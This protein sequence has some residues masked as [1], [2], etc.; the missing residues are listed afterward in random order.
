M[1]NHAVNVALIIVL[2]LGVYANTFNNAFVW[3]DE[4]FITENREIK[5][6][7]KWP[8]FFMQGSQN[9]YRPLRTA[10]YAVTWRFGGADPVL[11]HIVGKSLNTMAALVL[12]LLLMLLFASPPAAFWGTLLWALHP[13]HTEKVAFIT[14]TYD[15]LGDLFWLSAFACYVAFRK[16][17]R[18][19]WW[20]ASLALFSAGLFSAETAAVLPLLVV[21][22]DLTF[23]GADKKPLRWSPYFALLAVWLVI[24]TA[25]LGTVA[26]AGEHA[27]NPD[28]WGNLLTMAGVVSGYIKLL[29]FPWPLSVDYDV[30]AWG[31]P[32]LTFY[33]AALLITAALALA[34][35]RAKKEP[36]LAFSVFW[37]FLVL[38]PN[39]NIIPTGTL[40]TERYVYMPSAAIAF[41]AAAYWSRPT[42]SSA[43]FRAASALFI[44]VAIVFFGLTATRNRD[45]R[46]ETALWSATLKTNPHSNVALLNLGVDAFRKKEYPIAERLLLLAAAGRPERMAAPATL[47]DL[48]LEQKR[49]AEAEEWYRRSY[50]AGRREI[51]LLNAAMAAMGKGEFSRV[52]NELREIAERN[53]HS[54][55]ALSALG[56]ALCAEKREGWTPAFVRA[57]RASGEADPVL[58]LAS[59]YRYMGNMEGGRRIAHIGGLLFPGE[60]AF[61]EFF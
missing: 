49:F 5:D 35:R 40:M 47:G 4:L 2:S 28:L 31:P 39:L 33:I 11:Y 52:E 22:Y 6:L 61:A 16:K 56:V 41:L 1:K 43:S 42:A 58:K 23:G 54:A 29:V 53:P 26:R 9:L 20:W 60:N 24:R 12:Y 32:P 18:R 48:Y 30:A 19:G 51:D 44:I 59:C 45:W 27:I 50:A 34:A 38:S 7:S 46:N 13:I 3:D 21:M 37:F 36:W 10:L 8:A 25:A 55:E 17:G 57:H 14:S 15:I